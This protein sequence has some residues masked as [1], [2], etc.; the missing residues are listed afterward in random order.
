MIGEAR[1]NQARHLRG[2]I[3]TQG[4]HFTGVWFNKP[5]DTTRLNCAE[6]TLK[7]LGVLKRWQ[8]DPLVSMQ[9]KG[10]DGA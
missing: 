5:Q 4:N 9:L 7:H 3:R 6:A 8:R 10:R 1:C 2:H